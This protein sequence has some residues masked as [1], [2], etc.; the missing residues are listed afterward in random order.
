MALVSAVTTAR[1]QGDTDLV[2]SSSS[3]LTVEGSLKLGLN[4]GSN[5]LLYY[6]LNDGATRI[7]AVVAWTSGVSDATYSFTTSFTGTGAITFWTEEESI[8]DLP[9]GTFSYS[10]AIPVATVPVILSVLDDQP[11]ITGVVTSGTT[12]NDTSLL[13]SGSAQAGV[14]I[15]IYDGNGST[16]IGTTTADVNGLWSYT[17]SGLQNS[18]TYNFIASATNSGGVESTKTAAWVVAIDSAAPTAPTI[19]SVTDNANAGSIPGPVAAD[20]VS[21]DTSLVLSGTADTG[22]LVQIFDGSALLGS[23]IASAGDAWEFTANNLVNGRTYNFRVTASDANGNTS[24]YS[25][26]HAVRIDT[27]AAGAVGTPQITSVIDNVGAV[28]GMVASGDA[29]NDTQLVISGTGQANTPLELYATKGTTKTLVAALTVEND[30]TWSVGEVDW[31]FALEDGFTYT[32]TAESTDASGPV[33]SAGWVVTTDTTAPG[34]AIITSVTDNVGTITGP[35]ITGATSDDQILLLQGTAEENSTVKV[36]DGGVLIGT[37]KADNTRAWAFTTA[38]L[39]NLANHSFTA[40]STD[41]S[42]N[43]GPASAAFLVRT[44]ITAPIKPSFTVADNVGSEVTT[45]LVSGKTTD[46]ATLEFTG[47]AGANNQIILY[48]GSI[49][50]ARVTA[51]GS[52]A[53]TYTANVVDG[54]TYRFTA[55]ARNTTSGTLSEASD[56]FIVTADRTAPVITSPATALSIQENTG[57]QQVV[58]TAV[59][60]DAANGNEQVTSGISYSLAGTDA[61]LFSIVASTGVVKLIASPNYEGKQQYSFDVVATDSSGNSSSQNVVL[62]VLNL[63]E[64]APIITSGATAQAVNEGVANAVVYTVTSTDGGDVS[65]GVTYS[66]KGDGSTDDRESFSIN[67]V[68][69]EVTIDAPAVYSEAGYRFTVVA[70]DFAGNSVEQLITLRV[71]DLDLEAPTAP[72]INTVEGDNSI[73]FT[74]AGDGV[75]VSGTA[76]IG[77]TVTVTWGSVVKTVLGSANTAGTWTVTFTPTDLNLIG[78]GDWAISATAKDASN[79]VSVAGT[80]DVILDR[81]AD[82]PGAPLTLAVVAGNNII[83]A[84]EKTGGI[85][86]SGSAEAGASISIAWNG[87]TR[88]TTADASTGAWSLAYSTAEIPSDSTNSVITVTAKDKAGNVST[89]ISRSVVIDTAAPVAPVI[90][91]VAGNDIVNADEKTAGVTL[92]G[93]GEI[94]A[95]AAITWGSFSA[96][97][98]VNSSGIWRVVVPNGSVPPDN[99]S[100]SVSVTLTDA[101]GNTSAPGTK[102]VRIDTA[103]PK[104]PVINPVEGD[105]IITAAEK[106]DGLT[107]SGTAIAEDGSTVAITWGN[108]TRTATVSAGAWSLDYT[109]AQIPSD[110]ASSTISAVVTDTA[111]NTSGVGNRTVEIDTVAPGITIASLRFGDLVGTR[112]GTTDTGVIQTDFITSTRDQILNGTLSAALAAGDTVWVRLNN[113]GTTGSWIQ[114]NASGTTF[115]TSLNLGATDN[116]GSFDVQ[117]RD[118]VGN[119][120][121]TRNQTYTLDMTNAGVSISTFRLSADT[122]ISATDL[123]TNRANQTFSGTLS[124]NIAAGESVWYSLNGGTWTRASATT[125]SN[126]WSFTGNLSTA[127]GGANTIAVRHQDIAGNPSATSTYSVTYDAAAPTLSSLVLAPGGADNGYGVGDPVIVT[128]TFSENVFT[129]GTPRVALNVGGV[130]KYATYTAG[131]GTGSLTFSYTVV[132]GDTDANGISLAANALQLNQGTIR[133]AAGTNALITASAIA[134]QSN[135]RVDT[136]LP[137]LSG[138]AITGSGTQI[139]LTMSEPL[140]AGSVERDRF[141]LTNAPS[142]VSVSG[143]NASGNQVTLTLAGG[144]LTAANAA[145]LAVAYT[146]PTANNESS[147]V[148]QDAVGNDAA[149]WAARAATSFASNSSLTLEASTSITTASLTGDTEADLTGNALANTLIG[150]AGANK[151]TGGGGADILTGGGNFDTFVYGANSDS[152]LAG[153]DRIT[154]FNSGEDKIDIARLGGTSAT[155]VAAKN[156]TA[157]AVTALTQTGISRVLTNTTFGATDAAAVFQFGSNYY[158]AVNDGTRG[159]QS[160][161]DSII[162]LGS[163][164]SNP[165]F[166]PDQV[167]VF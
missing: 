51:D 100:S 137:T 34:T 97:T 27:S 65:N 82:D 55:V 136:G 129:T 142:G 126:T 50:L 106:A 132:S 167:Q 30:G 124:A 115:S 49:E 87:T 21:D 146:D 157:T 85:T 119:P 62:N 109:R 39:T 94:G 123:I 56:E 40:T 76:E 117:V 60:S 53:W 13:I 149:T 29:S 54:T 154:D 145:N 84:A 135:A 37:V 32:F 42:G 14:L 88:N 134:D 133:D 138:V 164:T 35:L 1:F 140:L 18:Q 5:P 16:P 72:V 43:T 75:V 24:D 69:G 2:S 156:L 46:D 41:Q 6:S 98:T 96:T 155:S 108:V 71:N 15:R 45:T 105:N 93:T 120:G 48:N 159:F 116:N 22:S 47:T 44:D 162:Q 11:G 160:A 111:G 23:V 127:N 8:G 102:S 63:D 104:P 80:R 73:N 101:A 139:V 66:L 83:N 4:T 152:L 128:A 143:A 58:Y 77:S 131:S 130:T 153:F 33:V 20:G 3:P 110:N 95:S 12:T 122:G 165:T 67:A 70:T 9:L 113:G 79:N 144:T 28:Q 89:P 125:G 10:A 148:I 103:A 161:T 163:T 26:P 81:I 68:T 158:L 25:A 31:S 52:G 61:A 112:G 64:V 59:A 114:A 92:S 121:A 91:T 38:Q 78:D 36:Y 147:G 99:D 118:A 19:S 151:I 74:E 7:A 107:L 90:N 57:A 150:N 86:L 166:N 17:A 141:V